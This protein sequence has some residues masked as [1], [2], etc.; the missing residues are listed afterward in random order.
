M[1]ASACTSVAVSSVF[2][3]A[4]VRHTAIRVR[5]QNRDKSIGAP[6]IDH[7]PWPPTKGDDARKSPDNLYHGDQCTFVQPFQKP[8]QQYEV[9]DVEVILSETSKLV[10]KKTK[11]QKQHPKQTVSD[12]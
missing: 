10:N 1:I 11:N 3:Y 12:S 7:N 8:S 9:D 4:G 6:L 2:L 5:C